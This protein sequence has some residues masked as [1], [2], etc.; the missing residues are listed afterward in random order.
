MERSLS[1]SE[2]ADLLGI[3]PDTLRR[4]ERQDRIQAERTPGGQ[5][6]YR[7]ADVKTLLGAPTPAYL[8]PMPAQARDQSYALFQAKLSTLI[9]K[10]SI[11]NPLP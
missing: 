8:C 4:W 2:A 11:R 3:T 9:L 7:E 1:P 5:R 10:R 6:R